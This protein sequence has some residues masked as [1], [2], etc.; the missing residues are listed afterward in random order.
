[1]QCGSCGAPILA[2]FKHALARNE[3]PAC[4]GPI[5]GEEYLALIED[6]S[7]TIRGEAAVRE[8]TANQLA[9]AL[10]AKYDISMKEGRQIEHHKQPVSAVNTGVSVPNEHKIAPPSTMRRAMQQN[11]AQSPTQ[12]AAQNVLPTPVV[13]EGISDTERD[14]IFEDAIREKYSMVDQIQADAMV[15]GASEEEGAEVP[16]V[17]SSP[18]SEG[19]VSPILEQERLARL[20]K[21]QNAMSGG[22]EGVFRRSS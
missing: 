16:P 9:M 8:D 21:Q 1:M 2:T 17:G 19:A 22:G 13:P 6:I 7:N 3:C 20:A 14:K 11:I 4:G 12:N 10:V 18:F 5:F 15:S